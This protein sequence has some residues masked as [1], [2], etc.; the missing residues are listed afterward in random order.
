MQLTVDVRSSA[1]MT[2]F[3][4][5]GKI[6]QGE[7]SD[8]LFDLLTRPDNRDVFLDMQAIREFDYTGLLTI[9]VCQEY[10]SSQQRCLVLRLPCAMA[11]RSGEAGRG[12][13]GQEDP[14]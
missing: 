11:A 2:A 1:Q 14:F 5:R 12:L 6:T 10:F 8:Y 4:C 13:P 3:T 9:V 7:E